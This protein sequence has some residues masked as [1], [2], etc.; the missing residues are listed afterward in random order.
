MNRTAAIGRVIEAQARNPHITGTT[1]WAN[2]ILNAAQDPSAIDCILHACTVT[3]CST[4][5]GTKSITLEGGA[6]TKSC[7]VC[8]GS[9]EKVTLLQTNQGG[10]V[11]FNVEGDPVGSFNKCMEAMGDRDSLATALDKL[12]ASSTPT[13]LSVWEGPMPESNGK[14]NFTA[15]L[16]RDG[17]ITS[18]MTIARSEYPGRVR[19]EADCVRWLLGELPDKPFI[20]DYDDKKHS[21]YVPRVE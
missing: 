12:K 17:D 9:G 20:C 2:Y 11:T 18:G 13:K 4:C 19:Y 10:R 14:T 16:C 21:G 8:N 5:K 1:N 6:V 7:P 3:P 15:I